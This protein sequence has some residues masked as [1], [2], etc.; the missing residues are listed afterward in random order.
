MFS[1]LYL[2]TVILSAV[3]TGEAISL[4]FRRVFHNARKTVFFILPIV[5]LPVA[6]AMFAVLVWLVRQIFGVH[7]VP[8]LSPAGELSL[9]FGTYLIVLITLFAP[10]L[11]GLALLNQYPM[12]VILRRNKA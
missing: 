7:F 10:F 4:L 1:A 3:V 2:S 8:A 11:Y 12:R 6:I 5:T 9:I